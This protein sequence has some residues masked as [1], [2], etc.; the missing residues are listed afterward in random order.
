MDLINLIAEYGGWSWLVAGVLLLAGLSWRLY[1]QLG[2]PAAT[3]VRGD[4]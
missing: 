2:D 3:E 4:H 1:R